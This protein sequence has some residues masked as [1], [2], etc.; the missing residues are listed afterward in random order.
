MKIEILR[1]CL[2]AP[3]IPDSGIL[4]QMRDMVKEFKF[5]L[6]ALFTKAIGKETWP[7]VEAG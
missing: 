5:G 4:T 6:M 7:M 3:S 2:M 1:H